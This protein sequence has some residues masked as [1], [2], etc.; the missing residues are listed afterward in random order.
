MARDQ[1]VSFLRPDAA[2]AVHFMV[3]QEEYGTYIYTE[4]KTAES[5]HGAVQPLGAARSNRMTPRERVLSALHH[6]VSDRVPRFEIWID[7]CYEAFG[8]TDPGA[9]TLPRARTA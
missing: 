1:G 4:G 5:R 7:A 2:A 9:C 6:E 8:C 3:S